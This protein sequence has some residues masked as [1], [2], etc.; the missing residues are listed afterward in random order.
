MFLLFGRVVPTAI[1]FSYST[2]FSISPFLY[3]SNDHTP[4]VL[5]WVTTVTTSNSTEV[6]GDIV[7][8]LDLYYSLLDYYFLYYVLASKL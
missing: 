3:I 5:E 1:I 8:M 4:L 7:T 6:S 2:N